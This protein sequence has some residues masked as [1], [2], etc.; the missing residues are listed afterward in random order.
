MVWGSQY[1]RGAKKVIV[2]I[3]IGWRRVLAPALIM[4]AI[5]TQGWRRSLSPGLVM[6]SLLTTGWFRRLE[7][8]LFLETEV[9]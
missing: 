9:S 6:S 2:L 4:S 5:P 3:T 8:G 1:I 7:I